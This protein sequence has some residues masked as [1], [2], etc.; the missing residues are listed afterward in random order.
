MIDMQK[1]RN[2]FKI[3]LKRYNDK[4]QLGFELK[5]THTYHVVRKC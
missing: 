5:V 4:N 3:F 2:A 1:A